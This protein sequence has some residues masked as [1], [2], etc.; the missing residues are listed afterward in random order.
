MTLP[1]YI[2]LLVLFAALMHAA[3]NAIVKSSASKL[4]DTATLSFAAGL[5]CL[6]ML[7]W[8]PLPERASWSWLAA[9]AVLHVFYF[10]TL[11][12]AYRWSDLSYAYPLMR[13]TAPLL[14]ALSG[15]FVLDDHLTAGMWAGIA[16]ITVGI[17]APVLWRPATV[18]SK[19]TL[20]ALANAVVI[21]CYTLIDGN[22][23]RASG[24]A[25]SYC[26]WLFSLDALPI[27][28]VA[29]A[30]HRRRAWDYAI[31]RWKPCT[32]GAIFT[33]G[34]YGIVLWA[35][36]RAPIAAVAVLRETSVIFAAIIGSTLLQERLGRL[37]I[38]GAVVVACGIAAL[39][40]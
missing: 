30:I 39:R 15:I 23:T 1:L 6:A 4:L 35:M 10:L 2:T 8:V 25:L 24:N 40:L 12:G 31:R 7:P 33:L 26:V 20:I 17:L 5:I 16:L 38:A 29:L 3:W 32:T 11:A 14:V 36:T 13:G 18:S 19:G 27:A 37:R 22:G 28:L 34:S 9:S 21:A